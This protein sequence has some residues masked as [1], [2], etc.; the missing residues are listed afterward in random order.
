MK[1]KSFIT[2]SFLLAVVTGIV[3]VQA[4]EQLGRFGIG[5][6][7]YFERTTDGLIR[8]QDGE[9]VAWESPSAGDDTI[10]QI[11]IGA[12]TTEYLPFAVTKSGRLYRGDA[13]SRRW[14]EVTRLPGVTASV[15]QDELF[16][17]DI[18]TRNRLF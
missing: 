5:M 11:E 3:P 13:A 7:S 18:F 8:V 1:C 9:P 10:Q 15:D 6:Q 17:A 2:R 4:A 16:V 14:S 12:T